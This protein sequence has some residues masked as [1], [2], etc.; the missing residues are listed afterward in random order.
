[1]LSIAKSKINLEK[2]QFL[3]ADLLNEWNF[4][5]TSVDLITSSL[6]LEHIKNLDSIFS[7]VNK[8]L[9]QKGL[10]Y[11]CE[12]HPFK[13]YLGSKAKFELNNN[14]VE[15]ET[16][17][18]HISEYMQSAE[19]NNFKLLKFSEWFDDDKRNEIPRLVSFLFQAL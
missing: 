4:K 2:V 19:I 11:I 6:V 18:H 9:K 3:Q 14:T 17:A 12:L 8:V 1:M 5:T 7:Q 10:F 15:L 16:Y 13:Q